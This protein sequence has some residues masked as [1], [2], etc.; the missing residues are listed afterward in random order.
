ML[1]GSIEVYGLWGRTSGEN[2][3]QTDP[4]QPGDAAE[5]LDARQDEGDDHGDGHI[6]GG[7]GGM[8]GDGVEGD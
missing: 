7:A 1:D 3:D 8:G 2:A 5:G 4:G 6:D